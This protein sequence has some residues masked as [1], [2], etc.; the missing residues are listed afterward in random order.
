MATTLDSK[1]TATTQQE[2]GFFGSTVALS[3]DYMAV[4]NLK[5]N[6]FKVEFFYNNAGTWESQTV[7]DLDNKPSLDDIAMY[8]NFV[9]VGIKDV[10]TTTK[11][12]V[13]QVLIFERS[14]TTWSLHTT[15]DSPE[16]IYGFNFGRLVSMHGDYL[17]VAPKETQGK[18]FIYKYNS[19]T[20]SW[21][22]PDVSGGNSNIINSRFV[23]EGNQYPEEKVFGNAISLYTD[24]ANDKYYLA[25]GMESDD[26]KYYF[27]CMKR[28][29]NNEQWTEFRN[30]K[31]YPKQSSQT[32][33]KFGYSIGIYDDT[34][35]VGAPREN[36]TNNNHTNAGILYIYTPKAT[37]TSVWIKKTS[38]Q[39]AAAYQGYNFKFGEH[40]E[41]IEN[42]ILT[43]SPG[44]STE[45]T[46]QV[47]YAFLYK[48]NGTSWNLEKRFEHDYTTESSDRFGNSLALDEEY[49]IIGAYYLD[50]TETNSGA[51]YEFQMEAYT[52]NED[53]GGGDSGGSGS[54]NSAAIC[55]LGDS[56]LKTDNRE[57]L[58][59]DN[60]YQTLRVVH[61]C[62][63]IDGRKILRVTKCRN[64]DR[65]MIKICAGALGP[66]VPSQNT[67]SSLQHKILVNGKLT[68]AKYLVNGSTIKKVYTGGKYM[69]NV[70]LNSHKTMIV[71]N[72]IVE[73]LH[74][75]DK[76]LREHPVD[77]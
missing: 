71:N 36:N 45:N 13:G 77:E 37:N 51:V 47:G 58:R 20:D 59:L 44:Y 39:P 48:H 29:T 32:F 25:I 21:T 66:E 2:N 41:I 10:D 53:S 40:V 27:K 69:Y 23:E 31:G 52:S 38:L 5:S 11:T 74:P 56:M 22:T 49:A 67:Y 16:N 55:F 68:K 72:M 4:G 64:S 3:G 70:L 61:P 30:T 63:S 28:N 24:S 1:I 57:P 43:S 54:G 26:N 19:G 15:I 75:G 14:G 76:Y 62:F 73:T 18:L 34:V 6:D 33:S 46:S 35:V 12:D 42:Y 60:V 7:I 8:G 50:G 65:Y 17:V 9:A